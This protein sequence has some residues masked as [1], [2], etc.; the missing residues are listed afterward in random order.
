MLFLQIMAGWIFLS[1]IATPFV[2]KFVFTSAT[3]NES[4]D[5]IGIHSLSGVR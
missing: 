2:G 5:E 3:E 1:C 4:D